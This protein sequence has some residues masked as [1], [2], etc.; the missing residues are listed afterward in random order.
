[1]LLEIKSKTRVDHSDV[2]ALE[3]LGHSIDKDADKWLLS[4]DSL[5]RKYGS[6][7][8]VHWHQAIEELFT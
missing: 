4:N 1:M 5:E 2:K 6:T 7:R 8:S 3:T